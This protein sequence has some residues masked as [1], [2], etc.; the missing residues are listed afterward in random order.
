MT[1]LRKEIDR[2]LAS[3]QVYYAHFVTKNDFPRIRKETTDD[4]L[5]LIEKWIDEFYENHTALPGIV[6]HM[7]KEELLK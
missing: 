5:K 6:Y 1:N 4:I 2:R 3:N 7:M